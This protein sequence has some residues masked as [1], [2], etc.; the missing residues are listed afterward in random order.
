MF[1]YCTVSLKKFHP[2]L[3][4][5]GLA[6]NPA[7]DMMYYIDSHAKS[8]YSYVY[9]NEIGMIK[10]KKV[11]IDYAQD[12]AL[13]LPDG[14]CTDEKGRLWVAS[15]GA[16]RV[17]C[18][19][20]E[21]KQKVM[22][23]MIPGAKNITSCCFGGPNYEWLFVTSAAGMLTEEELEAFPNSGSLFVI[24]DLGTRGTPANKFNL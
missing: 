7:D 18:W 2:V 8:I 23:V 5:N 12:D 17:T 24:K 15:F 21:T 11:L 6:W 9:D 13:A 4:S 16:Q 19:D 22:T 14:M 10:D 1:I 20:P 3:L